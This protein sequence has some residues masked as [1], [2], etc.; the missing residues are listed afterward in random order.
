MKIAVRAI[1]WSL[2]ATLIFFFLP[3]ATLPWRCIPDEEAGPDDGKRANVVLR[4]STMATVCK[5]VGVDV[6]VDDVA[7]GSG[8]DEG[9]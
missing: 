4:S 3:A 1:F 9:L 5:V 8:V 7:L 2:G 6:V